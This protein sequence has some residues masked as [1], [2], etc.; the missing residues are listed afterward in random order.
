M[1]ISEAFIDEL[2]KMSVIR[3]EGDKW[4]LYTSD[5]KR[6]LGT[7]PS[8]EKALAQE[9]AIEISKEKRRRT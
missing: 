4:K 5:G 8:R 9:R 6:V 7:H 3:Q 2:T 1:K